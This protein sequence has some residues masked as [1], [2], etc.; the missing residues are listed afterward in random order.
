MI[1]TGSPF[2]K[3]EELFSKAQQVLKD[4]GGKDVQITN[5]DT[6]FAVLA[7]LA[8]IENENSNIDPIFTILPTTEEFFDI[9]AN[10][11]EIIAP[12]TMNTKTWIPGVVGDEVAEIVYFKIDRYFDAIDLASKDILIQWTHEKY[13]DNTEACNFSIPYKKSL[14][15]VE[16]HIV[17]GWPLTKEITAE[18]GKILFSVRFYSR[19][20]EDPTILTYSFSTL[21]S[22]L[23]IQPA[24]D[25]DMD[26]NITARALDRAQQIYNNIHFG[27]Y[28]DLDYTIAVPAFTSY[29]WRIDTDSEYSNAPSEKIHHLPISFA[30]HAAVENTLVNKDA[31]VGLMGYKWFYNSDSGYDGVDLT[32]EQGDVVLDY[33]P[34]TGEYNPNETYYRIND[35]GEYEPYAPMGSG[36]VLDDGVE[37]YLR[38]SVCTPKVAGYFYA[39]G[40]NAY[41]I[42]QEEKV[43]SDVWLVPYPDE[44]V[45]VYNPDT[46]KIIL[47]EGKG[48]IEI[49]ANVTDDGEITYKWFFSA[50]NEFEGA[51]YLTTTTDGTLN[52]DKEGYYFLYAVNRKNN[53]DSKIPSLPISASYA[54]AKPEITQYYWGYQ[55]V[56]MP[57]TGLSVANAAQAVW[58]IAIKDMASLS[59]SV[60]YQWFFKPLG[61]GDDTRYTPVSDPSDSSFFEAIQNGMY[62]CKIVN[63]YRDNTEEV[64]SG[65]FNVFCF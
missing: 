19:H 12:K 22:T 25:F 42:G 59:D 46:R 9:N 56:A 2:S 61:S 49:A 35:E 6:Y 36:D 55:P 47:V 1:T 41:D 5:I 11:R 16:D 26:P 21:T 64:D 7:D 29:L 40:T 37:L 58:S 38:Y 50:N 34:Y 24:L 33:I 14:T 31:K 32:T 48:S 20:A 44:P 17:F 53:T 28:A 8:K 65:I 30:A 10:T 60:T 51:D 54:P 15:L 43:N 23:T 3:Y 27:G 57:E 62:Y 52:I 63:K 4:Y 18:P 39:E 13:K 45:Y